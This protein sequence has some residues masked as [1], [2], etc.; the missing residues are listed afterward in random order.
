MSETVTSPGEVAN[1]FAPGISDDDDAELAKLHGD[2]DEDD[3]DADETILERLIGL[4]EMFPERFRTVVSQIG[5]ASWEGSK[6]L[7]HVGQV[8][9]WVIASSATILALPVMFESERNQ[10]EEQQIQQQRQLLLGPNAAMSGVA[11]PGISA[12]TMPQVAPPAASR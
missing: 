4:T 6:W 12:S 2:D 3:E 5:S 7:Y 9:V 1:V 10:M 11:H 8:G